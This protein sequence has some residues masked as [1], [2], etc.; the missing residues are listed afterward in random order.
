MDVGSG[1]VRVYG[2]IYV[3]KTHPRLKA[4][5]RLFSFF[6]FFLITLLTVISGLRVRLPPPQ[7]LN[8]Q[9]QHW[10]GFEMN[11]V[12]IV[13]VF[14]MDILIIFLLS[15]PPYHVSTECLKPQGSIPVR[16]DTSCPTA[17]HLND[18]GWGLTYGAGDRDVSRP[19][20]TFF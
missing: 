14:R 8:P 10:Q 7:H 19:F 1:V 16:R 2:N 9:R 11:Q 6:S 20:S 18:D 17:C 5:V 15:Q 12:C 4:Q 3:D 13:K